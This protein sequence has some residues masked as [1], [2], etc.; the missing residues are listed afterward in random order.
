M[1]QEQ[2]L[3]PKGIIN[4]LYEKFPDM[5]SSA[6]ISHVVTDDENGGEL[7]VALLRSGDKT[8]NGGPVNPAKHKRH[9]KK[10]K[11]AKPGFAQEALG[12][13]D[14][15][16]TTLS[17]Q[18]M[19]LLHQPLQWDACMDK[20]HCGGAGPGHRKRRHHTDHGEP[21]VAA[22]QANNGIEGDDDIEDTPTTEVPQTDIDK[23]FDVM[24]EISKF[25]IRDAAPSS[26]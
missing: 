25:G 21:L 20:Q 1:E 6:A 22:G 14:G 4:A 2:Q 9:N 7:F 23:I 19:N 3:T 10:K 5:I 26:K 12:E 16:D 18:V 15:L 17:R 8:H 13:V 11:A 24:H